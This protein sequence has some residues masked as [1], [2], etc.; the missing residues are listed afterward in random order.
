MQSIILTGATGLVGSRFVE[1]YGNQYN[2]SNLDLATG[3]D[4]TSVA[5]VEQFLSTHPTDS[6]IHLAAFTDTARAEAEMGDKEGICYRVNVLGT[7]TISMG[8]KVHNIHLIHVSTD[9]VFDGTQSDPYTEGSPRSPLGWYG[10]TKALAEEE[11]EKSG[12]SYS[13]AR[14]SY[15]YRASFEQK[16]DL[17]SKIRSKLTTGD[18]PPQFSDSIITPTFI[19]D[20][21]A[22][23]SKL[24]YTKAQGIFH[25]TGSSSHSPYDLAIKVAEAYNLD[26]SL[27]QKG[28]LT[29]YLAKNPSPF[30]RFG[31]ISNAKVVAE[32]GLNFKT[33]DEGLN[34]LKKQQNL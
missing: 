3:V 24:V 19:D 9:F 26:K 33:L 2:I 10:T 4:I 14:I 21:A 18:L 6:L 31:V 30:A 29:D 8:C 27:I 20:I 5:Q 25:L 34:E 16:S 17:I 13:I 32:L 11:V 28:S 1:L 12:A 23:F 15:P 7:R 22:G